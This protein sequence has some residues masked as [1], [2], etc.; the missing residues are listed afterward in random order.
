MSVWP[1]QDKAGA[2]S[3]AGELTIGPRSIGS[4]HGSRV[5]ARVEL[6]RSLLPTVTD[7]L[8]S[9]TRLLEMIISRPSLRRMVVRVSRTELLSSD[10]GVAAV[11]SCCLL[12]LARSAVHV[13]T[14]MSKRSCCASVQGASS[15]A[16]E[17]LQRVK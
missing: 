12:Q 8:G 15:G 13:L 2:P 7:P 5:D 17:E 4:D 10:T 1:S 3:N 9:L 14:W 16:S 6:Q 11:Q